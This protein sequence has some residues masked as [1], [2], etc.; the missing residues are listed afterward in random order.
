MGRE[1]STRSATGSSRRWP[2]MVCRSWP[3]RSARLRRAAP[4]ASSRTVLGPQTKR[5]EN[6]AVECRDVRSRQRGARSARV[7]ARMEWRGR[8]WDEATRIR[9]IPER[10]TLL[11]CAPAS[12]CVRIRS[13]AVRRSSTNAVG[14]AARFSRHQFRASRSSRAAG[15]DTW[16]RSRFTRARGRRATHRHPRIPAVDALDAPGRRRSGSVSSRIL[17]KAGRRD[18]GA[19]AAA[20]KQRRRA[21]AA[22]RWRRTHLGQGREEAI[23]EVAPRHTVAYGARHRH[24]PWRRR[25]VCAHSEG[26]GCPCSEEAAMAGRGPETKKTGPERTSG[27]MPAG[28]A[29]PGT[30]PQEDRGAGQ[31]AG[32][33]TS[34][35]GSRS[36]REEGEESELGSEIRDREEGGDRIYVGSSRKVPRGSD[37]E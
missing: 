36:R 15:S 20:D 19:R 18:G 32:G 31:A 33:S 23:Q 24:R 14:A 7:D 8:A 21:P 29:N 35:S 16:M 12:G 6:S 9:R 22:A 13:S 34:I 10:R 2:K 1:S 25:N 4:T 11:A 5:P 3:S 27:R 30:R 37:I 17:R 26:A 28:G